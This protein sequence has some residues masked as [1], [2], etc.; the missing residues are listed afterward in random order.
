MLDYVKFK[1]LERESLENHINH[2]R[3]VDLSTSLNLFTGEEERCP[4]KGKYFN[5]DVVLTCKGAYVDGSIHILQNLLKGGEK[6]NYN[7]LSFY[8]ARESVGHLI[9][10]LGINKKTSLTNLEF[11][12][13]ICISKDPKQFLKFN[14]LMYDS[15]G[16]S[17]DSPFRGRGDYKE[18][19]R[20]DYYI[21]VYN[22]S[23][24]YGFKSNILRLE[25]KII[26]KRKLQKLGIFSLEDLQKED[27]IRRL[28]SFMWGELQKL[29]IIDDYRSINMTLEDMN[30]LN[31]YTNPNYWNIL[32]RDRTNK[33]VNDRKKKFKSLI[34]KYGLDTIQKEI[35]SKVSD[36][37]NQMM[38][39]PESNLKMAA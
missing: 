1:V 5:M 31:E 15:H 36:K 4:L 27:V 29:N 6:Q 39:V 24:H 38:E 11:G 22:K 26:Q 23:K 17:K 12:L 20:T 16:H 10:V 3:I 33:V 32:R 2:T 30:R 28:Y 19:Q 13:N 18:Y 35:L 37:F 9:K 7:D 14:L 25:V 8:S 34:I 21:K